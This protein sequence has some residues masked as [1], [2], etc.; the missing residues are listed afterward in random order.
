MSE[1]MTSDVVVVAPPEHDVESVRSHRRGA[2]HST[3]SLSAICGEWRGRGEAELAGMGAKSS[4]MDL[5]PMVFS[6][7]WRSAETWEDNA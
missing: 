3:I 5:T 6:I 4:S 1:S 2:N 7:C